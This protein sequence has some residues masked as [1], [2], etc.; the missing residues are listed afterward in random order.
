MGKATCRTGN[1]IQ[2]SVTSVAADPVA[3]EDVLVDV[4]VFGMCRH[5]ADIREIIV[6]RPNSRQLRSSQRTE[7]AVVHDVQ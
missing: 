5:S 1:C 7:A 6:E 2:A 3:D 4:E